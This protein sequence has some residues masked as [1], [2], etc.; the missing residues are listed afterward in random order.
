[1]KSNI[2]GAR[3]SLTPSF[4]LAIA[5]WEVVGHRSFTQF[6]EVTS[7]DT[8]DTPVEIWSGASRYPYSAPHTADIVSLSSDSAADTSDVLVYGLD[9]NGAEVSQTITLAGQ[10][11]VALDTPLWRVLVMTSEALE[12][13]ELAGTVYC[14]SGTTSTAGVPSGDSVIKLLIQEDHGRSFAALFTVPIGHVG[15]VLAYEGGV[16]RSQ[17]TGAADVIVS[18]RGY[19][20]VFKAFRR[21]Q[22]SNSGSSLARSEVS[23]PAPVPA[24]GDIRFTCY[25]V[26]DNNTSVYAHVDLLV[27]EE[28]CFSAEFL[29]RIGQPSNTEL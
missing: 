13:D 27:V 21:F 9:I 14:Y 4:L 2:G 29:A 18:A 19:Q 15:F 12:G 6:G 16:T 11:R 26:S 23:I 10:T 28:S 20:R 24:L 1:M 25:S 3:Y 17:T 8:N 5:K 7:I 22:V